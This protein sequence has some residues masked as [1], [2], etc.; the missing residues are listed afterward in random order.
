MLDVVG[1]AV[2]HLPFGH[3][4]GDRVAEALEA[5]LGVADPLH[6]KPDLDHGFGHEMPQFAQQRP[7]VGYRAAVIA[8]AQERI[9]IADAR[10]DRVE[11]A[12]VGGEVSVEDEV[13]VAA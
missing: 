1:D 3:S 4:L 10:V 6:A 2:D 7:L 13:V 11:G 5:A 8:V 9:V 12:Q